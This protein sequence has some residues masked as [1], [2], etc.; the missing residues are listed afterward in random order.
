MITNPSSKFDAATTGG[1]INIVLKKNRRAGLNG[2]VSAGLGTPSI[3]N[4]NIS[5]SLR[6]GKFN[7]FGSGNYNHSGGTGRGETQ[8]MN[9]KAGLVQ[10]YFDQLSETERIRKFTSM[11]FGLDFYLDNRNT[12]TVS[13]NFVDGNF[14]TSQ[15]QNQEYRN[16][17]NTLI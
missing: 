10:D 9:K 12:F 16:R 15:K 13:Q 2:V 6:Q 3:Y 4:G 5:L 17:N 14:S 8:R 1:I 11:R 7:F